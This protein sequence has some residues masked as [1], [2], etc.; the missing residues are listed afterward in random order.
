MHQRYTVNAL[1]DIFNAEEEAK[2]TRQ[3]FIG[4]AHLLID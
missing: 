4:S 2:I 1:Q 3:P